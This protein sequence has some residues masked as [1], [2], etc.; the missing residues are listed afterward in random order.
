MADTTFNV[1]V[2]ATPLTPKI[3]ALKAAI[4]AAQEA[5]EDLIS[6]V[7]E[8]TYAYEEETN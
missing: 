3:K 1:T 2:D 7:D 8:L 4:D 5:Y 6:S